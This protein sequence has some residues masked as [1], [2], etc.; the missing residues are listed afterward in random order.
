VAKRHVRQSKKQALGQYYT[1]KACDALQGYESVVCNKHVI[2][3]FAGNGDLLS[4]AQS[5]GALEVVGYDIQPTRND[6]IQRD[7]LLDP[8]DFSGSVVLSNPP[9]LSAN[10]CRTGDKRTYSM[11]GESDY[12]KCH[13]ASLENHGCD[14]A[15]V[16]LPTNFLCES[17]PSIR[18]RLFQTHH[19]VS[20]RYWSRPIFEDASTGV[21]LIHLRRGR[22]ESQHFPLDLVYQGV[23]VEVDLE[24]QYKYLW[25]QDFFEYIKGDKIKVLKTDEGMPPPNTH[26]VFGLLDRGKWKSGLTYNSG[27]PIYCAPKSFTTYQVTLPDYDLS[28]DQERQIVDLFNDRLGHFRRMYHDMFLSNY[29]G[30]D[31]KI[32]SRSYVHRLLARVIQDLGINT[33]PCTTPRPSTRRSKLQR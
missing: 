8:P 20:A 2:D 19:V 22:V 26:L 12:Y 30:P 16:I 9:Y 21:C 14:E 5:N 18:R 11:W 27:A 17:N 29:M 24:D 1:T 10:K 15:L 25:G 32:L 33:R 7:T 13:L 31:Q 4:W 28:E 6:Y 23:T 3:P